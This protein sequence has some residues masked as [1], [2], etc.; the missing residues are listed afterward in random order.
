MKRDA[1]PDAIAQRCDYA[2]LPGLAWRF[3]LMARPLDLDALVADGTLRRAGSDNRYAI[4]DLG[5]LPKELV[6]HLTCH[7]EVE[8]HPQGTVILTSRGIDPGP[9]EAGGRVARPVQCISQ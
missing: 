1:N 4:A 9:R 8:L 5:S 7:A 6:E 3:R 2:G